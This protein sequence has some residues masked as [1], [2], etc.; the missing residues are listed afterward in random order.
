MS[1]DKKVE[2][3][4]EKWRFFKI[5]QNKYTLKGN[6]YLAVGLVF[7]I[8]GLLFLVGGVSEA[9]KIFALRP[10]IALCI[11]AIFCFCAFAFNQSGAFMFV[12]LSTVVYGVLALLTEQ[13]VIH[14][15]LME[16]WPIM[17]IGC[18]VSLLLSGLY[19]KRQIKS[20][21]FFPSIMLICLGAIFLLFSLNI[22]DMSFVEFVGKWWPVL[23]IIGGLGLVALFLVQQSKYKKIFPYMEDDSLVDGEDN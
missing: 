4:K 13:S 12:G 3:T 14:L 11:G 1:E 5:P 19:S 16:L 10:F 17:V 20:V 8:L 15:T 2:K 7:I 22:I 23:L 9:E 21:Y 6:I 18:G